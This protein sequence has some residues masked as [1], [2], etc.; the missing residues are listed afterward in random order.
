MTTDLITTAK[1]MVERNKDGWE[2]S[3]WAGDAPALAKALLEIEALVYPGLYSPEWV[4]EY[5]E[6]DHM[7][8]LDHKDEIEY[9]ELIEA[10]LR[11]LHRTGDT[12]E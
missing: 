3:A 10:L 8:K 9:A 11:I 1:R 2:D 6:D 7:C 12:D 5:K 4:A